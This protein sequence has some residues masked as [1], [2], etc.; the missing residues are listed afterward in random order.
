MWVNISIEIPGKTLIQRLGRPNIFKT[1]RLLR[2]PFGGVS[3]RV[4]RVLLYNPGRKWL[5]GDIYQELVEESVKQ[6]REKFFQISF[7]SVSETIDSLDEA[8]LVRRY[9]MKIAV[10]E[11]NRLLSQWAEKYQ[12]RYKLL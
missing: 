10:P 11:P 3:S 4:L 9:G 1:P 6:G 12:E 8:L 7:S 5:V 2:N